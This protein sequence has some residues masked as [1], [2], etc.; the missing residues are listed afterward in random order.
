MAKIEW[1]SE[2]NLRQLSQSTT[3]LGAGRIL[4]AEGIGKTCL[5]RKVYLAQNASLIGKVYVGTRAIVMS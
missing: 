1:R 2:H 3:L 5:K 4:I